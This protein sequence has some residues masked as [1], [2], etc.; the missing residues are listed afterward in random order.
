M[1]TK[2]ELIKKLTEVKG[3]GPA[4]AEAIYNEGFDTIEKLAESSVEELT[5]IKGI[6]ETIAKAIIDHFTTLIE[7]KPP[8]RPVEK[9]I[10]KSVEKPVE[11]KPAEIEVEKPER[12]SEKPE[13]YQVKKKPVLSDEM[14]KRLALR[15][16]IKDRTPTFLRQE[17]FRYKRL[18]LTWRRPKGLTSKMRRNLKYRPKRVKVGFRGPKETRGLHPSGFQEVLVYN[19]KDL[20]KIDPNTQA[21]RIGSTVGTKKRM[22][23]QQRAKELDIRILN[24]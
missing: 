20:E 23:I 8:E 4:K 16:K 7:E 17:W 19:V 21:A 12:I 10:E 6:N 11:E 14:K 22:E 18:S 24:G 3:V 9:P 2:E 1:T 13:G 5:K 15:K